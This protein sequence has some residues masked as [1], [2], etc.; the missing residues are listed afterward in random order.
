MSF[1]Y[2]IPT[3][4]MNRFTA[5]VKAMVAYNIFILIFLNI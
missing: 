5:K 4:L 1:N 3:A 2:E